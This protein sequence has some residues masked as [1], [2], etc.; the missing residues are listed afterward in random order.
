[1]RFRGLLSNPFARRRSW[2]RGSAKGAMGPIIAAPRGSAPRGGASGRQE[3]SDLLDEL[4]EGRLAFEEQM[5]ASLQLHE[6]GAWD[7]RRHPATGFEW[8]TGVVARVQHERRHAHPGEQP[9]DIDVAG[10]IEELSS[11]K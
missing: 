6:P 8:N 9:A 4:A 5:V 7:A 10:R 3:G 2:R 11:T 1:M